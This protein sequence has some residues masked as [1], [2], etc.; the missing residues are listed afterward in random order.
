MMIKG[1]VAKIESKTSIIINRGAKDG[2]KEG[3]KFLIYVIGEEILDPETNESLGVMER[4]RGKARVTHVQERIAVLESCM[5]EEYLDEYLK[6]RSRESE[7]KPKPFRDVKVG[8]LA[9]RID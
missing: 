2:V 8:D 9:R 3:D 7:S 6:I 5:T 4:V 1:K